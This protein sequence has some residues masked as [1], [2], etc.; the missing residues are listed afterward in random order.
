M[1]D[2]RSFEERIEEQKKPLTWTVFLWKKKIFSSAGARS[3]CR[4]TLKFLN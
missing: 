1:S 4:D 3:R 2:E